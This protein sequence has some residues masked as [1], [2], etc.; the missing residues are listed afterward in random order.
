MKSGTENLSDKSSGES[1][2]DKFCYDYPRPMVTVDIIV[3]EKKRKKV[4]LI[5]RKKEPYRG[6]WALPGGYVEIE[7][8]ARTSALRELKEETGIEAGDLDFFHY[9]DAPGRDPRGRTFSLV[10]F[11][12]AENDL[13]LCPGTDAEKACWFSA[14]SLPVLAFDHANIL[15]DFLQKIKE[16][17][18]D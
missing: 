6:A 5:R 4:L 3:F 10:F 12:I 14:D 9:Y 11:L 13:P 16:T 1:C 17:L 7:E 15:R 18:H 8:P 2:Q